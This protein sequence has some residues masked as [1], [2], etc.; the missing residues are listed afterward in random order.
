MITE[1]GV[2]FLDFIIRK[3]RIQENQLITEIHKFCV[4]KSFELLGFLYISILPEKGILEESDIIKNRNCFSQFLK[5]KIDGTCLEYNIELFGN[6][7]E[8]INASDSE[9]EM[10]EAS[11]GLFA[12]K[13]FGKTWSK[14]FS[15]QFR[16]ATKKNIFI[17]R[18]AGYLQTE[19]KGKMLRYV[20]TRL[21]F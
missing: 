17:L 18:R 16:N 2:A 21:W 15:P 7:L 13:L 4:Y 14:E 20:P 19:Q 6:L 11:Y 10:K 3:N 1:T 12:F 5:E 9:S 8:I